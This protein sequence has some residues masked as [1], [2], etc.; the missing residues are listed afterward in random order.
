MPV[1]TS[2]VEPAAGGIDGDVDGHGDVV[3]GVG[4]DEG[5]GSA[6]LLTVVHGGVPKP[7]TPEACGVEVWQSPKAS[8]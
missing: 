8:T 2:E 7:I 5:G 1:T 3:P 6:A 4:D